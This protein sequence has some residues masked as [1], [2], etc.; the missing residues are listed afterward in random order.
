MTRLNKTALKLLSAIVEATKKNEVYYVTQPEA[1]SLVSE[2]QLIEVNKQMIKDNKAA[3]RAT[4]AGI[5]MVAPTVTIAPVTADAT[6]NGGSKFEVMSGMS[7]PKSKRG[8]GGGG[9][10]T[11][12]PFDKLDVNQFFFVPATAEKPDPAK[13]L[14]SGVASAN[15]KYSKG[16]GEFETVERT[17]R[18]EGNKAVVDAAGNKVKETVQREKRESLRKFVIRPVEAGQT[19]GQ[20]QCPANG[21][22]VYRTM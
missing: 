1:Q 9:A 4:A 8:G 19:Y 14:Q 17:K 11:K 18:G 15:N 2:P 10:P 7:L 13:S 5:E 6:V 3:C 16:T 12:Y 22:V 20:W 21:A